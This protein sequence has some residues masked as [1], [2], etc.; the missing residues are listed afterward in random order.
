MLN[1]SFK[2]ISAVYEKEGSKKIGYFVPGTRI[3]IK[4]DKFFFKNEI[5][6]KTII[7]FAWHISKEI[8]FYLRKKKFKGRIVQILEEKDFNV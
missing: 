8:N 6:S 1:L 3:P 2:N 7:N 5:N 4:S